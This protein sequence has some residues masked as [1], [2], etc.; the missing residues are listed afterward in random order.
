MFSIKFITRH[1]Q[2]HV[3]PKDQYNNKKLKIDDKTRLKLYLLSANP[4]AVCTVS[5]TSMLTAIW[6]LSW[7]RQWSSLVGNPK[8]LCS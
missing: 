8:F 1:F 6:H 4:E 5:P 2:L 7:D 3:Y